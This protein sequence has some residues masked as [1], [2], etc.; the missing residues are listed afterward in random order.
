MTYNKNDPYSNGATQRDYTDPYGNQQHGWEIGGH[1]YKDQEGTTPIDVGSTVNAGGKTWIMTPNGGMAVNP[2]E[3]QYKKQFQFDLNGDALYQQYKDQY[4][5]NGQRAMMDTMGQAA[6]LT[7]G[8][9]S[10][11]G[12]AVGQ[13][14][15]NEYMTNLGAIAGDVYDRQYAAWQD[16]LARE[17]EAKDDAYTKALM[18]VQNGQMPSDYLLYLSGMDKNG[19]QGIVD[20]YN[21]EKG[22]TYAMEL[23]Q[24]GIMP[25][26]EQ[27]SAAG[28]SAEQAKMILAYYQGGTSGG[29]GSSGGSSW[30]PDSNDSWT[31]DYDPSSNSDVLYFLANHSQSYLT[32]SGIK[33]AIDEKFPGSDSQSAA[34]R[35]YLYSKYGI[36]G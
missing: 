16:D 24:Y 34:N 22:R 31:P 6:G 30:R 5:K 1:T 12:Q 36:T 23:M 21:Q 3:V 32:K 25:T 4:V 35:Q 9:G 15:Y 20:S 28:I 26:Q 2:N 17:D 27:L 10:S 29:T 8:Y 7:G 33:A 11:Y 19:A 18:L 13:Q 14:A